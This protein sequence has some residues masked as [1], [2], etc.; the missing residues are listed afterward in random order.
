MS[1]DDLA[2]KKKCSCITDLCASF[3]SYY[4]Y[5]VSDILY[6]KRRVSFHQY[7]TVYTSKK[8]VYSAIR[9]RSKENWFVY[10][11]NFRSKILENETSCSSTTM[12]FNEPSRYHFHPNKEQPKTNIH[13]TWYLFICKTVLNIPQILFYFHPSACGIYKLYIS[14]TPRPYITLKM[15][16]LWYCTWAKGA[17]LWYSA[18]TRFF[19]VVL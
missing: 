9:Y 8:V 7:L 3:M 12:P 15:Q 6:R 14:Y 2:S 4:I 18:I 5:I 17:I 16:H 19:F 10:C 1:E 13:L 11:R